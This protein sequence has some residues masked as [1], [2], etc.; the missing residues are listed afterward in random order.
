MN[1]IKSQ[2]ASGQ[3]MGVISG[4]SESA[5]LQPPTPCSINTAVSL[6]SPVIASS[7][8]LFSPLSH[9]LSCTAE[10]A[11]SSQSAS[12]TVVAGCGRVLLTC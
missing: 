11:E 2:Q 9:N 3:V 8:V 10:Q 6:V 4:W 12:F 1:A 7:C 5:G